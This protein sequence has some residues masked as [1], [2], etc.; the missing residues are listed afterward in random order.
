MMLCAQSCTLAP[1][2]SYLTEVHNDVV[3]A[4]LHTRSLILLHGTGQVTGKVLRDLSNYS[5]TVFI[6]L[7]IRKLKLT[8]FS[9]EIQRLSNHHIDP[10][11]LPLDN[12]GPDRCQRQ[13]QWI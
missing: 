12:N 4:V 1:S 10:N 2:I 3:R 9:S 6:V 5:F 8:T 13:K 11:K 7:Q